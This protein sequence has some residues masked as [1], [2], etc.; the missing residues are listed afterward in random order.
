VVSKAMEETINEDKMNLLGFLR[1]ELN[2]YSI[3]INLVLTAAEE[4]TNLYTATDRY[5]WLLE[6]NPN[7]NKFRQAFDLDIGF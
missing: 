7:L 1:K 2:N 6:K 3:Q 4:K 5:K